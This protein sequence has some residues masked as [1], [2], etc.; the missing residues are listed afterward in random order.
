MRQSQLLM[1]VL[2]V[3]ISPVIAQTPLLHGEATVPVIRQYLKLVAS[4]AQ[5]TPEGWKRTGKLFDKWSVYPQDS[6]II[7]MSTEGAVGETWETNDRAKVETKWTD[8]FG[9]IDAALRYHPP[10]DPEVVMTDYIFYLTLI[11]SS[12]ASGQSGQTWKI[13]GPYTKRYATVRRAIA[14]VIR[15][16]DKSKNS[17]VRANAQRTIIVLE[18]LTRSCGRASAC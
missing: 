17:T 12:S 14:Y 18:H 3:G 15:M 4:G 10:E 2:F 16:R 9:T 13:E 5:L 1:L 6:T 8:Y 11:N 7:L